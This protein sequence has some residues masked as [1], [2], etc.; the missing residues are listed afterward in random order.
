LPSAVSLMLSSSFLISAAHASQPYSLS[1]HDALPIW[2]VFPCG[3]ARQYLNC[4]TSS[5]SSVDIAMSCCAARCESPQLTAMSTELRE[6][7]SEENTSELQSLT[8]LVCRLLL[9]KNTIG[10]LNVRAAT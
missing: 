1:L 4:D 3:D 5:R 10:A 2:R 9:E 6:L 7:R 8:N